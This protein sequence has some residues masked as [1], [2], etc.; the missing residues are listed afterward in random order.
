MFT[1][2]DA[3]RVQRDLGLGDRHV[4]Y[5]DPACGF[6]MAHTDA[7]RAAGQEVMNACRFHYWLT[8]ISCDEAWLPFV[9]SG[10]LAVPGWYEMLTLTSSKGIAL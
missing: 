5:V 2:E 10:L 1:I 3:K 4:V 9:G 8:V 6:V 7:E